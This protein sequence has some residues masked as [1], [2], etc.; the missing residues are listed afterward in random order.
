MDDTYQQ[1]VFISVS[2]ICF[3]MIYYQLSMLNTCISIRY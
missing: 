1:E 2:E 3:E